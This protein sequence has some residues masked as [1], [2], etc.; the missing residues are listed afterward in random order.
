ML[1][2]EQNGSRKIAT[3]SEKGKI[4]ICPECREEVVLKKGKILT[5]HFAHKSN[6]DC[7]RSKGESKEHLRAK[8]L[9]Y[10]WAKERKMSCELEM[11]LDTPMGKRIADIYIEHKGNRFAIEIQ[12][13]P[14][15]D[16]DLEKRTE[17][18]RSIS[19]HVIWV[20]ML[21]KNENIPNW[22]TWIIL[23]N[24][25]RCWFWDHE[26]EGFWMPNIV[27]MSST[28]GKP[29]FDWM[30]IHRKTTTYSLLHLGLKSDYSSSINMQIHKPHKPGSKSF[31]IALIE[32]IVG[33]LYL[34]SE[35]PIEWQPH[36]I[37]LYKKN[38]VIVCKDNEFTINWW[39]PEISYLVFHW[40]SPFIEIIRMYK[41]A[42]QASKQVCLV[43][44]GE[45]VRPVKFLLHKHI[46]DKNIKAI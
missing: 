25:N 40:E 10:E 3:Y 13:S 19:V 9:I 14:I 5:H 34:R 44:K 16:I 32:G 22:Q 26:E 23:A 38:H 7:A 11:P 43:L 39:S 15:E 41:A 33:C 6:S 28:K 37:G 31:H 12:K 4:Y 17:S 42:Q 21:K 36:P 2:A 29:Y 24:N 1:I 8:I 18:Y 46:G 45:E 27:T 35:K 30:G 20:P